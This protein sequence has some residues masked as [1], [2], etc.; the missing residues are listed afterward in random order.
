[1]K[2]TNWLPAPQ[3]YLLNQMCVI[4]NDAFGDYGCYLVGSALTKR[5]YRDVDV[6]FIMKDQKY[7]QLF[8]TNLPA[9]MNPL[10]SLLCTSISLFL[11]THT[12]LPVDF[13]IQQMTRANAENDGERHPLGVF[14]CP[15]S[16]DYAASMADGQSKPEI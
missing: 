14:V 8:G 11:S 12:G 9:H 4:I 6:R 7:D 15:T 2:R 13:Q 16:R 3:A 10:W 5:E 1:M